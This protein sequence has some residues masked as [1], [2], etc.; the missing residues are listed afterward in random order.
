MYMQGLILTCLSTCL[1]DKE[2]TENVVVVFD[3]RNHFT[4]ENAS[5]FP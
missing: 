3:A 4:K 1:S 5:L 2:V